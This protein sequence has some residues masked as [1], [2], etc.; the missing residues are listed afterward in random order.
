MDLKN[1]GFGRLLFILC[2]YGKQW[3]LLQNCVNI[4][5]GFSMTLT[6]IISGFSTNTVS[7]ERKCS[8]GVL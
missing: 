3:T 6:I 7:S 5:S 1:L 8:S 4:L 2:Q